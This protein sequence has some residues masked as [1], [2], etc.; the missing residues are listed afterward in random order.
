MKE[1]LGRPS[2][3]FD[4]GANSGNKTL[5]YRSLG[6]SV[7]AV[8][9]QDSMCE[10]L[11][12]YFNYDSKVVVERVAL[13]EVAG[14]ADM[15]VC[16]KFT[17]ISAIK[18]DL[19]FRSRFKEELTQARSARVQ[20]TTLD[21][22]IAKYGVPSFC[23]VDTEGYELQVIRGL[24]QPIHFLSL[25]LNREYMDSI[26]ECLKHLSGLSQIE[27]NFSEAETSSFSF[28]KWVSPQELLDFIQANPN[29]LVWGDVYVKSGG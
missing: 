25:E 9:P 4:V 16:D 3:V 27:V 12:D 21:A 23:K 15:L 17:P 5:L 8:E 22:L 1:L 29:P 13:G 20:V 26:E 14:S 2:L 24:S 19:L 28:E 11:S 18:S 7:V 10:F 6:A